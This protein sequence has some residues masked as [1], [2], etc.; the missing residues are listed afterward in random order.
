MAGGLGE[1][2][3]FDRIRTVSG[4]DPIVTD[5]LIEIFRS[6]TVRHLSELTE[7]A[8]KDDQPAVRDTLHNLKGAS[9]NVG[10]RGLERIAREALEAPREYLTAEAVD[11]IHERLHHEFERVLAILRAWRAQR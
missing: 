1:P 9:A 5:G 10:A 8:R 4:R 7:A 11:A 2:V 3:D 6:E